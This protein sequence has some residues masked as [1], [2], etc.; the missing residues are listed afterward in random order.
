MRGPLCAIIAGLLLCS[1]GAS[2]QT[3]DIENDDT[4]VRVVRP[5]A[6]EGAEQVEAVTEGAAGEEE[7]G[8]TKWQRARAR[9]FKRAPRYQGEIE[10]G[11]E[12]RGA[13]L[14]PIAPVETSFREGAVLRHLDKMT[15]ETRT[16]EMVVGAETMA[17]R[18]KVSLSACRAP[19]DD[20]SRGTMAFLKVWDTKHAD[21]PP[22]FSGWMFA[23]SPALSALDHSRY[24]LWVINCTARAPEDP[25]ESASK[26]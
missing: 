26:E 6:A 15:G 25:E 21:R 22:I 5:S 23:D 24:D 7:E 13:T 17:D 12:G 11:T 8:L 2:A 18:L 3:Q 4:R 9:R 19:E 16:F 1:A 20:G 10:V 14:A